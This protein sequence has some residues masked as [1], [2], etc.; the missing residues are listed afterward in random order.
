MNSIA[1]EC[2]NL[3]EEY[4][5]CFNL[6]FCEHFLK[7]KTDDSMC[8]PLFKAYQECVKKALKDKSIEIED[9]EQ[10]AVASENSDKMK[11]SW[12]LF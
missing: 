11:Y 4:D 7:G 5:A 12:M 3:K 9:V 1:N 6:W 8:A 2:Q 10:N